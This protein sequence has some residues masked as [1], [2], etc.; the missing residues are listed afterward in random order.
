M[1]KRHTSLATAIYRA[2]QRIRPYVRETPLDFSPELSARCA[3]EVYLKLENLQYTG[4]FKLRGA[5]HYLLSLS[6]EQRRKG[7]VAAS[8]GNHGAAVAY[9]M[10]C[11]LYTS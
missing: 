2:E 1:N 3:A 6:P 11:L 4:S 7:V 9:G 8:S 5:M 10:H